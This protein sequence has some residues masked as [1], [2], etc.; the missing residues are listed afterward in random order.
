MCLNHSDP[1]SD[2]RPTSP[3]KRQ[4]DSALVN[5]SD[6]P[7]FGYSLQNPL[8]LTDPLGLRLQFTAPGLRRFFD[9]AVLHGPPEFFYAQ[10]WIWHS[11]RK[12]KLDLLSTGSTTRARSQL[13]SQAPGRG[14]FVD[15]TYQ[16][17]FIDDRDPSCENILGDIVR[18]I[19]EVYAAQV[20]GL[21]A[22]RDPRLGG[23]GDASR[24]AD[25]VVAQARSLGCLSCV[26][27]RPLASSGN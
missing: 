21:S 19:T 26:C 18:E 16:T 17:I 11:R 2:S 3:A 15:P 7:R 20:K 25:P 24:Y 13:N 14:S 27:S 9:C 12:W 5:P 10:N 22:D 4:V 23:L 8:R 6:Q 1:A